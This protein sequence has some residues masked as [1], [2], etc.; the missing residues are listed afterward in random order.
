VVPA[1]V[2]VSTTPPAPDVVL[3]DSGSVATANLKW[4]RPSGKGPLRK[5][6]SDV[7]TTASVASR[8][9]L[10]KKPAVESSVSLDTTD[11]DVYE[12]PASQ[13][14]P[15]KRAVLGRGAKA[16]AAANLVVFSDSASVTDAESVPIPSPIKKVC[17][18][19]YSHS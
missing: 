18:I 11:T 2:N 17:T 19:S 13:I 12:P 6:P 14:R 3:Q 8:P 4:S 10:T 9:P 1:V 16:Q 5:R 7:A 15:Q